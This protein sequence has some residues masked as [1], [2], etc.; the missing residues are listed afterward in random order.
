MRK[1]V[2][3]LQIRLDRPARIKVGKLGTFHFPK[4]RYIYTGSA[5]CGLEKRLRRYF[6]KDKKPHWHIDYLLEKAEIEGVLTVETETRIECDLNRLVLNLPGA[7]VIVKGF[8][9]S[10]CNCPSHLVHLSNEKRNEDQ[11]RSCGKQL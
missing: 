6:K 7:K 10:D 4:G 8:G 9:S 1:G 11:R 3:L 5:L 2:Y